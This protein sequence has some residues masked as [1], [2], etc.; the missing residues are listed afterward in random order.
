M[1]MKQRCHNEK[2]PNYENYG[3]RGIKVSNDWMDFNNFINDMGQPPK[4]HLSIDR[5]DNDKGYNI[6]NCR[7]ATV[8]VQSANK[9]CNVMIT[10]PIG[11]VC[12]NHVAYIY[13]INL[14][15]IRV[16]YK[17]HG[18]NL[19]MLIQPNN[20]SDYNIKIARKLKLI[21]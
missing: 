12:R 7:W 17:K 11:N 18:D 20:P 15:T 6:D 21:K 8:D 1:N 9:R 2:H 4:E 5:I 10:T 16:R 19:K 3:G 13:G 14:S